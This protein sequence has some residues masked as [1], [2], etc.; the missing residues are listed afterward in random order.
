MGTLTPLGISLVATA[1]RELCMPSDLQFE[2]AGKQAWIETNN[3]PGPIKM[4]K[5]LL[6]PR[7]QGD[8]ECDWIWLELGSI[9]RTDTDRKSTRLNSSH[10]A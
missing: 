8:K 9:S 10:L 1:K 3:L 5:T 6:N 7:T 4:C 2:A